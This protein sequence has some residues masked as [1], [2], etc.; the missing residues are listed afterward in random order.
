LLATTYL[1]EQV[2]LQLDALLIGTNRNDMLVCHFSGECVLCN[3][4]ARL[5]WHDRDAPPS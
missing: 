1:P 3:P 5:L 4:R 2:Y